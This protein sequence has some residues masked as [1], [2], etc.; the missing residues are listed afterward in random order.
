MDV[1]VAALFL[2][3]L[4]IFWLAYRYYSR[5]IGKLFDENPANP[6]PAVELR[7]EVDFVPTRRQ[8]LFGHHFASI[9]GGGPIIGPTCAAA[10][11][12]I[13]VFLWIVLGT[14]FIG[15]A[16]DFAALFVSVRE[17]G[18][19]MAEVARTSLGRAGFFLFISFTIVMLLLVTSAFLGLTSVAL[20]SLRPLKD[21]GLPEGQTIVKTVIV[22]GVAMGRIGGI[23]SMS[24]IVITC[25]A[26]F[27]GYLLYKRNVS[28]IIGTV[29]AITVCCVSVFVGFS[30]PITFKPETWMIILSIYTIF[31]AGIPVW[32]VLQ[33]RDYTNSFILYA[34]VLVLSVGLI[35]GGM[36]DIWLQAPA[37]NIAFGVKNI[38]LIWPFLF[39]TVAC[40]AIS[41][42]HALVAGG[43]TSKQLS[44]E[45]DAR[46]I[47]FG[48]MILEGI[49]ALAVLLAVASGIHFNDYREIVFP[50][51]AGVKS[52]PILAFSA[53][54]AGLLHKSIGVS[55]VY[56]TVFGILLVEG[57]VVTTL[58]TAVR[59][60]RYLIEE[61]WSFIFKNVPKILKSYIVN[62]GIAVILMYL[63]ARYNAFLVI[64]PIF[65]TANQLLAALTLIVVSVW[66]ARRGKSVWF[67]AL[68]AA[69][70]MVTTLAALIWLLLNN[71][72]PKHNI[73]LVIADILLLVLSVGVFAM[74]I[75]SV[76]SIR[77]Q[78]A[79]AAKA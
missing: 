33:P 47:A 4:P 27:I 9:A 6:T 51:A 17:K 61:L 32:I 60:N 44:N 72:L 3:A 58:D 74:V 1:N 78:K 34:G 25:C 23:A 8:V 14:V 70:M 43:T 10:F 64:W 46:P 12:Y 79:T 31:A 48:G 38:G 37:F 16:H 22:N 29:L 39:I 63:L 35:A 24:V 56:G 7:D 19:S 73:P 20:T 69:F 49:L 68:P 2:I 28:T 77:G 21:L 41:G 67:S 18:K 42:F 5:Y 36:K 55:P 11:G 15:A 76:S 71:Y 54:M 65:G 66:L 62:A 59:L 45:A 75:K 52:N 50:T 57:F 40:G 30:Y 26:P 53:G 13:P